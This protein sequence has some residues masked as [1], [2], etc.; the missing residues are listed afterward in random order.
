MLS[1][2][3]ET[4]QGSLDDFD[5]AEVW[6][7]FV[8]WVDAS[9][10]LDERVRLDARGGVVY[11]VPV[12]TPRVTLTDA[13]VVVSRL[14]MAMMKVKGQERN[15]MLE[16]AMLVLIVRGSLALSLRVVLGELLWA[17]RP[18]RQRCG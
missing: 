12:A 17:P 2:V 8:H 1:L 11:N 16:W 3:A 15:I 13:D 5:V 14:L 9:N 7:G 10:H 4:C 6:V 18:P